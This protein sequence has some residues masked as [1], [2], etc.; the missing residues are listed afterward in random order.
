MGLAVEPEFWIELYPCL[1]SGKCR[2][3]HYFYWGVVVTLVWACV[4]L[5]DVTRSFSSLPGL[6]GAPTCY[7]YSEHTP[8]KSDR[9]MLEP[10]EWAAIMPFSA[11][12]LK[13][14]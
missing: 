1:L 11:I 5:D 6:K 3:R 4:H 12:R 13:T 10:Q 14:N 9:F 8:I 7:T 2:P